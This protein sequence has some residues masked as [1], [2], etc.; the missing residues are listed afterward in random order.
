[1]DMASLK[2]EKDG[3]FEIIFLLY[4]TLIHRVLNFASNKCFS[5]LPKH[6][7]IKNNTVWNVLHQNDFLMSVLEA[8][9]W[10]EISRREPFSME[11][12][13]KYTDLIDWNEISSNGYVVWTV[14]GIDKFSRRIN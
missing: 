11:M 13:E 6:K 5:I 8:D 4:H 9:A 10:K 1:M 2:H 12:I 7:N 3:K 14:E